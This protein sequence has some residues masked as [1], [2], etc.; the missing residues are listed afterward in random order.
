MHSGFTASVMMMYER[1][2]RKN[3]VFSHFSPGTRA[4]APVRGFEEWAILRVS[5]A[6]CANSENNVQFK[7]SLRIY[8][9]C[10]FVS[11]F[12]MCQLINVNAKIFC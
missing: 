4:H 5:F 10:F 11:L 7:S 1:C 9:L 8:L 12:F 6:L 3:R 2:L